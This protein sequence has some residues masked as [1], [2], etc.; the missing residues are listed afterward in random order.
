MS[1][2]NDP[3]NL[4]AKR[5][6][7]RA[8]HLLRTTE[9]MVPVAF[10]AIAD[11][12]FL[13]NPVWSSQ[14]VINWTASIGRSPK[15]RLVNVDKSGSRNAEGGTRNITIHDKIAQMARFEASMA[16][17]DVADTYQRPKRNSKARKSIWLSN[18]ISYTPDLWTG[19][20]PTNSMA[21][22]DTIDAGVR[23]TK[24]FKVWRF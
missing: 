12:V 8:S 10:K 21:L 2:A 4:F 9:R 15:V 19:A 13:N 18:R 5:M 17:H 3:L 16:A 11:Q 1:N 6:K 24:K 14:S 22:A 7:R 23:A 20:W